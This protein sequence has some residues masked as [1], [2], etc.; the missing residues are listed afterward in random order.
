MFITRVSLLLIIILMGVTIHTLTMHTITYTDL[1]ALQHCAYRH[2][3]TVALIG[4]I[5]PTMWV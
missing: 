2:K 3:N 5:I 4:A 1:I